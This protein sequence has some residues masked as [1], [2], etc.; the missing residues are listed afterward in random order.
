MRT[1]IHTTVAGLLAAVLLAAA[2]AATAQSHHSASPRGA[3]DVVKVK[4]VDFA[5]KP[6]TVTIPKGSAV[7]WINKGSVTH[8]TTSDTGLWSKDLKPGDSFK[9]TFKRVGTFKYHCRF[10]SNMTGK[11]S[12]TG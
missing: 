4:V 5:F 9:R 11:I 6:G 7:K 10:H 12:V 3:S 2:P 8:S 1:T